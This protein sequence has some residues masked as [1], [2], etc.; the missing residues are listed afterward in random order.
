MH[1][2]IEVGGKKLQATVDT[3]VDG[4]MVKELTNVISLPYKKEK[5]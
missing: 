4:Y 3:E 1:V 5:G 2:G